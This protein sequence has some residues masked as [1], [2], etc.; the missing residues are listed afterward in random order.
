[1]WCAQL[2]FECHNV[3]PCQR[4]LGSSSTALVAGYAAGLAL[5]GKELYAPITKKLLLQMAADEEGHAD[6]IAAAIY[7]GFQVSF[8]K[9][10]KNRTQWITQRVHVPRGLHCVIYIPDE[11]HTTSTETSRGTLPAYYRREDVVHNLGRT[12]MLVNCFATGQFDALRFA[13]EDRL[14][15]QYRAGLFPFEP[16][17]HAALK[18]GAHGA[19]LSSQVHGMCMACA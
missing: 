2:R 16:L 6:N 8:K 5:A 14:H 1:M 19:F 18:A 15:Q 7:G 17:L 9:E 12:A 3:V 13:M 11:K 4:G 10:H